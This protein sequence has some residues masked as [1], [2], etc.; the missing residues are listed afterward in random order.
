MYVF[1]HASKYY[2]SSYCLYIFSVWISSNTLQSRPA[3]WDG[4][5]PN[6]NIRL[7]IQH[8]TLHWN[9]GKNIRLPLLGKGI[10]WKIMLLWHSILSDIAVADGWENKGKAIQATFPPSRANC[11]GCFNSIK[12]KASSLQLLFI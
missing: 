2:V 6:L 1:I 7:N 4:I 3:S 12:R 9:S 8:T 10:T 11:S 5:F